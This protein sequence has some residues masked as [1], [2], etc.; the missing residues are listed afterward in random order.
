MGKYQKLMKTEN[1]L[2]DKWAISKETEP[3]NGQM[4]RKY[5]Y[6]YNMA[7]TNTQYRPKQNKQYLPARQNSDDGTRRQIDYILIWKTE[8]G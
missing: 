5:C 8:I 7:A 4:P 6:K 1:R 3:G 2:I